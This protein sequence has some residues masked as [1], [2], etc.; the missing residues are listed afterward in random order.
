MHCSFAL[1]HGPSDARQCRV[2]QKQKVPVPLKRSSPAV[3]PG[4]KSQRGE[5]G[6]KALAGSIMGWQGLDAAGEPAK[7]QGTKLPKIPSGVL[8][9]LQMPREMGSKAIICGAGS[10]PESLKIIASVAA[11]RIYKKYSKEK[12]CLH[13][14]CMISKQA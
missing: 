14:V 12:E 7:K 9:R 8:H 10:L 1:L 6:H 11:T 3:S 4:L 2:L 5:G 13:C